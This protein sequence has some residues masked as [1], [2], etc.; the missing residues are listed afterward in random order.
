M[1]NWLEELRPYA[2]EPRTS[3]GWRLAKAGWRLL[4]RDGTLRALTLLTA[5]AL[6]FPYVVGIL[7]H[8]ASLWGSRPGLAVTIL[9]DGIA[10]VA[11]TFLLVATAAA[12]DAAVD[13]LPLRPGEA[14]GDARQCLLPILGW[15]PVVLAIWVGARGAGEAVSSPWLSGAVGL[16]L[17]A[18]TLF[19]V[20][21]IAVDRLGPLAAVRESLRLLGGRW[22]QALA[23]LIGIAAFALLALVVPGTLLIH[24]SALH[25]EGNPVDYPLLAVGLGLIVLVAA[26]S[27]A[28]REAFAVLLFR[29]ALEDLPGREH[30][31][32]RLRRQA[33]IGRLLGGVAL[34]C[35]LL[36]LV[37]AATRSDRRTNDAARAPGDDFTTLVSNPAGVDLPSG[38]AVIYRG[39]KIGV[40]LGSHSNGAN[41]EVTLHVDPG[42]S[43]DDTPGFFRIVRSRALGPLLVLFPGPS[44]GGPEAQPA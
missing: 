10:I 28:T 35:A 24:A 27:A 43:P 18:A 4:R 14:L 5:L 9:L 12:A 33:K 36:L 16:A 44:L 21:A 20:P 31:G 42:F 32:P 15:A 40:V 23:G 1:G 17:F 30:A 2:G 38:S 41:L 22:R 26:V 39:A 11:T 8:A 19:V 13:G 7:G 3:A 29:E 37:G 34:G 6:G 25:H